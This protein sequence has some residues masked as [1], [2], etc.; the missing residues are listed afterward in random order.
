MNLATEIPNWKSAVTKIKNILISNPNLG[1]KAN[2][3]GDIYKGKR[4][5]M[6]VDVVC[7]RQRNYDKRVLADLLPQYESRAKDLSLKSLSMSAPTYL[8][9]SE[10]PLT[11]QRVAQKIMDFGFKNSL[12]N[13]D[14]ICNRWA[15]SDT[16]W[17][18]LEINGIGPVLLEY[19]RMLCGVDTIKLD[20]NVGKALEVLGIATRGYPQ[21]IVLMICNQLA[22]DV[23]CTLIELDQA[24]F[25]LGQSVKKSK[26]R[27]ERFGLADATGLKVIKR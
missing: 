10:E 25:Q 6:V 17:L 3:F 19:L 11:M 20:V 4:G 13:E 22:K 24:L 2:L 27:V 12:E 9:N 14:E 1:I 8:I 26:I 16:Y 23:G 21:N 7:S 15:C 5:L 18:M